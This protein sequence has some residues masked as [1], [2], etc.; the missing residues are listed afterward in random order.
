[1]AIDDIYDE[2]EQGERVRDW[3][4]RNSLG[5]LAGI[6]LGLALIFG[7]QYWQKYQLDQRMQAGTAFQAVV[8]NVAA[9]NLEQA[10]T[11]AAGLEGDTYRVLAGLELAKAQVEADDFDA[12][13]ATLQGAA[14]SDPA[15]EPL[16]RQRL[17]Q[18]LLE[19]GQAQQA[20]ELLSGSGQ[21]AALESLGDAHAALDQRDQA[22]EAYAS[23]LDGMAADAPQRRLLELKLIDAGGQPAQPGTI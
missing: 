2:H 19:A 1:M 12:A 15:L 23:A 18:V 20:V 21:P 22:R 3:L 9:G 5:L 11:L 4:R 17:A 6:G 8:D 13:V 14:S 16:R 7:W 10:Q